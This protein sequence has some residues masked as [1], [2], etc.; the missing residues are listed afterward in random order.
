HTLHSSLLPDANFTYMRQ[1]HAVHAVHAA[2]TDRQDLASPAPP[3]QA[4]DGVEHRPAAHNAV[5]PAPAADDAMAEPAGVHGDQLGH[6]VTLVDDRALDMQ[7]WPPHFLLYTSHAPFHSLL[8][9]HAFPLAL[10][11]SCPVFGSHAFLACLILP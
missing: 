11:I 7:H 10:F 2:I 1:M 9:E 4:A 6:F 8:Q 5:A 3:D